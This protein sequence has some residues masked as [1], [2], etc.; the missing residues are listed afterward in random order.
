M[1]AA[2]LA[3]VAVV[4]TQPGLM[5]QGSYRSG[6]AVYAA[7]EGWEV[8]EDGS[9]FFVFGYMNENWEEEPNVPIGPDNFVVAVQAGQEV[10]AFDQETADQGQPTRFLPRR[11]RF[12]FRVPVP[13]GY[14]LDDEMVWSLT[15]HGET[16]TAH[17]SLI[18]I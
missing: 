3:I 12:V 15:T 10:G 9:R 5:A 8:D 1:A 2:L 6:Q 13:E 14:G 11:N 7:Y 4:M 16:I 18:H 17:L